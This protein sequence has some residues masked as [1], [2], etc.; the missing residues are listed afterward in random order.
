M[1]WGQI[2]INKFIN[3]ALELGGYKIT[4]EKALLECATEKIGNKKKNLTWYE[5]Y[6]W[7][8]NEDYFEFVNYIKKELIKLMPL[9]SDEERKIELA[10]ILALCSMNHTKYPIE[11]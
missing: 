11:E 3:K 6:K 2:L 7:K 1:Q 9:S 10:N 8:N 5:K 4:I